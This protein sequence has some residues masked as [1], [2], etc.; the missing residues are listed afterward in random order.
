MACQYIL[1]I[2]RIKIIL[3][4]AVKFDMVI[5]AGAVMVTST[6][7]RDASECYQRGQQWCVTKA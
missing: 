2:P 4:Y 3:A 7:G 5:V 1:L 6:Q